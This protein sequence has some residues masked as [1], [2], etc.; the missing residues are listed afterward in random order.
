MAGRQS[1]AVDEALRLIA[2]EGWTAY[3]AAKEVNIAL[4]TI[5]RARKRQ[6][7]AGPALGGSSS[8]LPVS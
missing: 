1:S 4:S 5:Y 3:K 7:N 8:A 6:S 2:E